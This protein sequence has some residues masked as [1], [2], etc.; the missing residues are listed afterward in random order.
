[1]RDPL[2]VMSNPAS[3]NQLIA[4]RRLLAERFPS[5]QRPAARSLPTG[6]SAFD[7]ITGGLPLGAVTEVVCAAPSCGGHLFLGQLL[8][9][10]RMRRQRAALVDAMDAFDP[11]SFPADHLAH[12]V[13]VRG[14]GSIATALAAADL[15]ARDANLGLVVLDLRDASGSELRRTPPTL[16][17][18]LQ[19]AVEGTDLSF[20]VQTSHAL[21]PSAR[22]RLELDR[23]LPLTA[24]D[25]DR[26]ALVDT[27]APVVARQRLT[28]AAG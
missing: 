7:E 10:T 17:Y 2:S 3:S 14:N 25:Q 24:L 28:A 8:G 15:L 23:P 22:L 4:L 6:L 26:P 27:L 19:R 18:R 5:V 13:W 11:A 1:M 20:V 21:V 9:L 16:W 12:L